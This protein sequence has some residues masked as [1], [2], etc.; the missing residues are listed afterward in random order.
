[1]VKLAAP[2]QVSRTSSVSS[3]SAGPALTRQSR[4]SPKRIRAGSV[5]ERMTSTTRAPV[6]AVAPS[7]PMRASGSVPSKRVAATTSRSPAVATMRGPSV[8]TTTPPEVRHR[9]RSPSACT[10]LAMPRRDPSVS[11]S[12]AS[13]CTASPG[14]SQAASGRAVLASNR[15]SGSGIGQ[16]ITRSTSAPE[17]LPQAPSSSRARRKSPRTTRR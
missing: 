9:R 6:T 8:A 1:L 5:S 7:S 4:R 11:A 14:V 10:S 15:L 17:L 2:R 3:T 13:A 12:A 16:T